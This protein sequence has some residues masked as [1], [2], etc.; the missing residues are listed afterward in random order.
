MIAQTK[1]INP[2][3]DSDSI[4]KILLRES[5]FVQNLLSLLPIPT[6]ALQGKYILTSKLIQ[7]I[8][9]FSFQIKMKRKMINPP[10]IQ[11]IIIISRKRREH[12]A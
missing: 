5:H 10:Q 3:S 9:L 7:V 4:K 12:K 11:I 6:S 1:N 8:I 2:K